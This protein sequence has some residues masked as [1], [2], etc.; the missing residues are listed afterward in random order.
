MRVHSLCSGSPRE[1]GDHNLGPPHPHHQVAAARA[2][3]PAQI[4][5]GVEQEIGAVRSGAVEA[6]GG[7]AEVAGIEDEDGEEGGGGADGGVERLVVVEA[8][9]SS[10]PYERAAATGGAGGTG[11]EGAGEAGRGGGERG[12][13]GGCGGVEAGGAARG[14]GGGRGVEAD[15]E[16]GD[17]GG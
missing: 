5:D 3:T 8:Q 16:G 11:R 14:G 13:E 10:E 2:E 6:R 4:G 17:L 1:L 9:V 7:L 15:G 12:E